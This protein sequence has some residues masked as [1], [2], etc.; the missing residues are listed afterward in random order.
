MTVRG[1]G[2]RDRSLFPDDDLTTYVTE[3][4]G[5]V[6]GCKVEEIFAVDPENESGFANSVRRSLT[7]ELAARIESRAPGTGASEGGG[8][9]G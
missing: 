8:R 7:H 9:V 2:R 1:D 4:Y 3:M 6:M 5:P